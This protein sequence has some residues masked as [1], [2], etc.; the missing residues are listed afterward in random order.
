MMPI[1]IMTKQAIGEEIIRWLPHDEAYV[2]T[3]VVFAKENGLISESE[4]IQARA[5][6]S[7]Y[8]A[9]RNPETI[10]PH[11]KEL[12]VALFPVLGFS[13]SRVFWRLVD[14]APDRADKHGWFK[15]D[16]KNLEK[17]LNANKAQVFSI[18]HN[19]TSKGFIERKEGGIIRIAYAKAE[20][21][22]AEAK[23]RDNKN[24]DGI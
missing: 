21:V 14:Q 12:M 20:Q 5:S 2:S 18:I 24:A 11:R 1:M 4:S 3:L 16:A 19:L 7:E 8:W 10:Q 6:I 9:K 22:L 23:T 15:P 17:F 13:E